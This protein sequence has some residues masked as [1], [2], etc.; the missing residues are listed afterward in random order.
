[1]D[2]AEAISYLQSYYKHHDCTCEQ[3][4]VERCCSCQVA[5]KLNEVGRILREGLE[6]IEAEQAKGDDH[7][8]DPR[9]V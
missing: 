9:G 1:M 8:G 5:E 6:L 4:Q 2:T 7:G 3:D